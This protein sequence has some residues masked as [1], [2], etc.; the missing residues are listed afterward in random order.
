MVED[1]P[2]GVVSTSKGRDEV[3]GR[4]RSP[5]AAAADSDFFAGSDRE[6]EIFEREDAGA[7]TTA[8]AAA[9]GFSL[10]FIDVTVPKLVTHPAS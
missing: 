5:A 9:D 4:D 2:L 1:L 10:C 6:V 3:V 7:A 8:T